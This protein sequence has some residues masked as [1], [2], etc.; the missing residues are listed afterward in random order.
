MKKMS[1]LASVLLATG[2]MASTVQ[3]P[4]ALANDNERK[5]IKT[6]KDKHIDNK[7]KENYF[8]ALKKFSNLTWNFE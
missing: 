4:S 6:T 8:K 7:S 2:V 3:M 1:K 5:E